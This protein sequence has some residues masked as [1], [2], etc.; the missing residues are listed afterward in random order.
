MLLVYF[1][2]RV[3]RCT[4]CSFVEKETNMFRRSVWRLKEVKCDV[5]VIGGGPAGIAAAL[6]AVDYHKSVCLIEKN[7]IGGADFWN[8]ALQSKT[9]WEISK[10]VRTFRGD[11]S[12]RFADRTISATLDQEKIRT[13]INNAAELREKQTLDQLTAAGVYPIFGQATFC[14]PE[15]VE[16][17][18]NDGLVD[19]IKA[20][21]YILATGSRPRQHP[22]YPADGKTIVTSDEIMQQNLPSSIVII[23]AGVIGCEFASILANLGDTK[24]KVIEKANRILPMEDEDIALFV[25]KL[26]AR[27][28]VTFHHHS[29]LK[30]LE[31]KEGGVHYT[32][33]DKRTGDDSTFVVEK[34]L[35]SIGRV[36]HYGGLGLENLP[37]A[38]VE[39]GK[40]KKDGHLRLC[41]YEHIYV[42]GDAAMDIALV[43]VGELE[44]RRTIDHIYSPKPPSI[45][46]NQFDNLSTIMF[47][48]QEV[49]AVGKNE[50]D[51]Q[52]EKIAYRC[53]VYGYDFVS[54]AV[55]MG[56]TKGF[57][58]LICTNDRQQI[59][60]GVRAIGPQASSVVELASLAIH[61]RQSAFDLQALLTA[62]PSVTNGFQE[63]LRLLL[64]NSILKPD[65]F[66][67]LKLREWSPPDFSIRGRAY[68]SKDTKIQAS[69]QG[70]V[71]KQ[72]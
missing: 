27:K 68:S 62:Y 53:A 32:I 72:N 44:G 36:P 18:R 47:L 48:D 37:S 26:L 17:Q 70:Q 21:Y 8:G 56:N 51:C 28:K 10:F 66:P 31:V 13:Q 7:R 59:V 55:A 41:G 61:N 30:H 35:V 39:N 58:K 43:N 33:T 60:L 40:I 67:L 3:L 52:K 25:E 16:V 29:A 46:A 24:V 11:T 9:L 64:G 19:H 50:Q 69:L 38:K 1:S 49:A 54:R 23:G 14:N 63:C 42:C 2:S 22:Q 71:D 34:A 15:K 65:V 5:C 6:R 45:S 4:F 57:V 20:D 12:Q